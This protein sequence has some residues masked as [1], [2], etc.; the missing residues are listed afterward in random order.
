MIFPRPQTHELDCLLSFLPI[1][2]G[3]LCPHILSLIK[4]FG[5]ILILDNLLLANVELLKG[6]HRPASFH[7]ELWYILGLLSF[8]HGEQRSLDIHLLHVDASILSG[9][10]Q[11]HLVILLKPE[12]S[13]SNLCHLLEG[14]SIT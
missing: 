13:S 11:E 8:I 7:E 4:L 5:I 2:L 6:C 3:L 1:S 9:I 10:H 12:I 14:L